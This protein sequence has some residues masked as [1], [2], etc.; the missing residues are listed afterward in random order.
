[1]LVRTKEQ[2]V[3]LLIKI[4]EHQKRRKRYASSDQGRIQNFP[5]RGGGG[6]GG[7]GCLNPLYEKPV[8]FRPDTKSGWRG[9]CPL[10]ARYEKREEGAAS[11]YEK[12]GG[13]A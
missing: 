9:G 6:G 10:R 8:R 13:A 4:W 11:G 5:K 1:M 7:G 3:L 12:R 2:N